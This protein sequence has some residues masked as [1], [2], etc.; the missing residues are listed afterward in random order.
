MTN[1]LIAMAKADILAHTKV[2]GKSECGC[3]QAQEVRLNALIVLLKA[4]HNHIREMIESELAM[5]V[6]ALGGKW[7]IDAGE[8]SQVQ[9]LFT[10][11]VLDNPRR[12]EYTAQV[13]P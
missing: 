11:Q 4:E 8:R 1:E 7:L 5:A 2:C 12:I 10:R 3:L 9:L 13:V 6:L